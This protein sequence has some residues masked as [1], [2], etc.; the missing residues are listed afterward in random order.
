VEGDPCDKGILEQAGA[1]TARALIAL[2][3]DSE[4]LMSICSKAQD[5]FE[6]PTVIARTNDP[7]LAE[8]LRARN[9]AAVQPAMA[10]ALALEGALQFP[11][12]FAMLIDKASNVD[13]LD[14]PLK[15]PAYADKPLKRIKLPRDMLILGIRHKGEILV[16]HGDTIMHRGDILLLVGST[17]SLQEARMMLMGLPPQKGNS[18]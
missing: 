5:L 4:I 12:S 7:Q 2:A 11:A 16:P 13:L 6:I 1:F 17:D 18:A 10:T 15:N 3:S 9:I 14:V 8:K